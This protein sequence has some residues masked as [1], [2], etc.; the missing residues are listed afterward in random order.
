MW[1][2]KPIEMLL[3]KRGEKKWL[4]KVKKVKAK[5]KA[6]VNNKKGVNRYGL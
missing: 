5:A 6:N 3:I 2:I 4:A 1:H